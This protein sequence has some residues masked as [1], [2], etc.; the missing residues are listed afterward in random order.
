MRKQEQVYGSEATKQEP[1]TAL[2]I[3]RDKVRRHN[4]AKNIPKDVV[5]TNGAPPSSSSPL[6]KGAGAGGREASASPLKSPPSSP[7]T[8]TGDDGDASDGTGAAQRQ[9][10]DLVDEDDD[11]F[12]KGMAQ[13]P[14][15]N[16]ETFSV[17]DGDGSGSR[18]GGGGGE[19]KGKGKAMTP[20]RDRKRKMAKFDAKTADGF[21]QDGR[22][23]LAKFAESSATAV[24]NLAGAIVGMTKREAAGGG[25]AASAGAGAGH[26]E[27]RRMSKIASN[28][29]TCELMLQFRSATGNTGLDDREGT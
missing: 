22:G 2:Q 11:D 24:N 16:K 21:I 1:V 12:E 14:A 7:P 3:A 10:V 17:G 28:Q 6:A 26:E 20:P 15:L 25:G 8:D 13:S 4:P 9:E 5:E 18:A 19:G 27:G 29:R 23:T